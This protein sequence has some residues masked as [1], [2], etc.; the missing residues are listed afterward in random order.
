M[1]PNP[2][3]PG[4]VYQTIRGPLKFI[5]LDVYHGEETYHFKSAQEGSIYNTQEYMKNFI[6]PTPNQNVKL[7]IIS[8]EEE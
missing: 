4:A 6:L 8:D 7:Q 1:I 5:G 2:L 3:I